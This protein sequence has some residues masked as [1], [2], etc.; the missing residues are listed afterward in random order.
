MSISGSLN[1]ALSGLRAA[2]R[3]SEV[4]ASNISNALTEGFAQRGLSLSPSQIGGAGGVQINGITRFVDPVLIADRRLADAEFGN[5]LA[6]SRFLADLETLVGDPES[7]ASLS[8]RLSQFEVS[9]ISA[10]SRPDLPQRHDLAIDSAKDLSANLKGISDGLQKL[11]SDA[12]SSIN[13]QVTRL[14]EALQQVEKLNTQ[15][16]ATSR[17]RDTQHAALLDLRQQVVDEISEMVPVREVSRD[18]GAIA[19]YTTGGA[20][21]LDGSAATLEFSPTRV[22]VPHM[23]VQNTLLSGLTINGLPVRTGSDDGVLRGGSIGAQFAIRDETAV[24]AQAQIDAV[25]R[26]LVERFQDPAVDPTLL[27]GDAGLFTDGGLAFAAM[28]EIG[29]S[30]RLAINTAVDPAQGGEAWRLRAGIGAAVPG[31]V[32]DAT[33]LTA[34]RD[35]LSAGRTPASGS[36]GTSP[37]SAFDLSAHIHSQIGAD[38]FAMDRS[39]SF[40]ANSLQALTQ[41]E[42]ESGVDT[43]AELQHLMVL[44]QAYAAN[45][46]VIEAVDEMM[47]SILRL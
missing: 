30:G 21:L 41:I 35:A 47:Q 34:L 16:I 8:G 37:Q 32:G 6:N 26:D 5:V 46:R 24:A 10:A 11:R 1:N 17:G 4:V 39:M 33:L 36:F 42:L 19:L 23:T 22:I 3:G 43:D 12:D 14:N 27:P 9:L 40:S 18:Y 44:E 29:L 31:E 20:I 15:I 25:A 7:D 2:G 28:N 45:A 38:R 13:A